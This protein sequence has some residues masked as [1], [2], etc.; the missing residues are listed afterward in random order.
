MPPQRMSPQRLSL[1][2]RRAV[3]RIDLDALRSNIDVMR[4]RAGSAD[5]MAVVKAD[6]YGHGMV[7]VARAA[8]EAG[9]AW[10]GVALPSEAMAL[11]A[12]G[13]TGRVLAWLWAPG[14]PGVRACVAADVDLS[15]SS[16]W[17]VEEVLQAAR[18]TGH[19]ARVHLKV[20]TGLTRNGATFEELPE[21][22]HALGAGVAEGVLVV[23]GMWSHLADGD[24]PGAES[25]RHQRDR[26]EEAWQIVRAAGIEPR[27][28]HLANSGAILAHPD[29]HY[30]LVRTGIALY[31]LTPAPVLGSSEGLGLT[32]VMTLAARLA[33]VKDVPAG[34]AVSYGWRWSASEPTRLGLVPLGYADGVP[35]AAGA[36]RGGPGVEVAVAGEC[37]PMV[38]TVA[39]DQFVVDL[40]ARSTATVGEQVLLFGPGSAGEWTA[41]EWAEAIG[42]IGY[43]IVTRIGPRVE[44]EFVGSRHARES[45]S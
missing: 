25:V 18:D 40:G 28:R 37:R 33:H 4:A 8:R 17:S 38:G 36:P 34:T 2:G 16:R 44:R 24:T 1:E 5:V 20:D 7:P 10:L 41:D 6:G 27:L 31:G 29:C 45:G 14:D 13:D 19:V 22:L 3:A 39:M 9:V 12:A 23:E 26:F 21:V 43:E 32:P 30:D 42:T 15:V 35:R 11:R